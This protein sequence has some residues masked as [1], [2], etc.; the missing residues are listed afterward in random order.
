MKLELTEEQ[1][2]TLEG[3]LA[4]ILDTEQDLDDEDTGTLSVV[5]NCQDLQEA[6][7]KQKREAQIEDP[8]DAQWNAEQVDRNERKIYHE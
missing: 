4:Y 5:K 6:I 7:E 2:K 8:C 3:V 1:L